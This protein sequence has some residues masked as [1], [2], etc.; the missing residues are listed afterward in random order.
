VLLAGNQTGADTAGA[1]KDEPPQAFIISGGCR[2]ETLEFECIAPVNRSRRL[3]CE[4]GLSLLCVPSTAHDSRQ[5]SAGPLCS[6]MQSDAPLAAR[7]VYRP[8][9]DRGSILSGAFGTH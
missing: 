6:L 1:F 2:D 7:A 4:E 9:R 5:R 8:Q 3:Y